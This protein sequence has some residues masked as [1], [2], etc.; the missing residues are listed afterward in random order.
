MSTSLIAVLIAVFIFVLGVGCVLFFII[1]TG[2]ADTIYKDYR[3]GEDV[4]TV[5]LLREKDCLFDTYDVKIT[6]CEP[7]LPPP[8]R[9]AYIKQFFNTKVYQEIY[10]RP[11]LETI[12]LEDFIIQEIEDVIKRE[13]RKACLEKEWQDFCETNNIVIEKEKP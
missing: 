8:S 3:I 11:S 4:F 1:P 2:Q 13:K 6:I 10:W 12:S 5:H 9:W 7:H